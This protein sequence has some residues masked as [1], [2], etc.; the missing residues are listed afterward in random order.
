LQPLQE[1]ESIIEVSRLEFRVLVPTFS[2]VALAA[3]FLVAALAANRYA[4]KII[5]LYTPAT[6]TGSAFAASRKKVRPLGSN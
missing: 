3:T 4:P 6:A 5:F 1:E 2:L